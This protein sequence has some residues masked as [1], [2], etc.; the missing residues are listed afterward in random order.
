[1]ANSV[2]HKPVAVREARRKFDFPSENNAVPDVKGISQ[3]ELTWLLLGGKAFI[4]HK[5]KTNLEFYRAIKK[6][7]PKLSVD[8]LARAMKIPMTI[9][10]PLLNLS[11]KTLTRKNK[12]E[13][14]D[15]T[16][17]SH[18]FEIANTI[19]KGLAV[20]EDSDK[21][22]RWLNKEN[23]ALSSARPF[24]LLGTQ[25]GIKLVNQILGRIEEGVYS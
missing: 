10:A 5:P 2:K 4:A 9:M 22:N 7:I 16:V 3:S 20:F 12:V 1:M 18:T 24:D 14:L 15:S 17:S 21:L 11:Y 25:T 23:R 19:A 13:M 6:G 8:H